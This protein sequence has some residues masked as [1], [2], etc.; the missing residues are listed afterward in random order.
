MNYRDKHW[1]SWCL[2]EGEGGCSGNE[3]TCPKAGYKASLDEEEP[4]KI[5][6]AAL[7]E[8]FESGPAREP[9]GMPT[10]ICHPTAGGG[11]G[12]EELDPKPDCYSTELD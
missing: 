4:P 2:T 8:R 11:S 5:G 7:R 10:N 12:N 6:M 1:V 3:E 9:A